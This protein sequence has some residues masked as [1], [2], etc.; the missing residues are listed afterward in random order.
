MTSGQ[1]AA[2]H[3]LLRYWFDFLDPGKVIERIGQPVLD[4]GLGSQGGPQGA[5]DLPRARQSAS[6]AME[7]PPTLAVN[8]VAEG[9]KTLPPTPPAPYERP[10][11]VTSRT[12]RVCPPN[13]SGRARAFAATRIHRQ[14]N[15]SLLRELERQQLWFEWKV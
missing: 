12:R 7:H 1:P 15:P 14:W 9:T 6:A 8:R 4:G 3:S 11:S 13:G 2:A 5:H 10:W